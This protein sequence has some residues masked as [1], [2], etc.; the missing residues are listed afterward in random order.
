MQVGDARD[1]SVLET[2]EK[3][4]WQL[5]Q[6]PGEICVGGKKGMQSGERTGDVSKSKFTGG[7]PM[8]AGKSK[9]APGK[10]VLKSL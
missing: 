3:K 9:A 2:D 10:E 1:K 8:Q 4:R 5:P 6:K 7:D